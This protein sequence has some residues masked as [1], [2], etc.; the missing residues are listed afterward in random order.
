MRELASRRQIMIGFQDHDADKVSRENHLGV[1]RQS[2]QLSAGVAN[3]RGDPRP[4]LHDLHPAV[5]PK[6]HPD[7]VTAAIEVQTAI[8]AVSAPFQGGRLRWR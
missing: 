2:L 1:L 8:V 5:P 4:F 7:P 3:E 6:P